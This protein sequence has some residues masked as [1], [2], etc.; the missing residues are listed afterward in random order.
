MLEHLV[1]SHMGGYYISDGDPEFIEAYC[2]TCGDYDMILTSWNT[3]ED[4]ARL[5]AL[6]RYFVGNSINNREELENKVIEYDDYCE[7]KSDIIEYIIND[8]KF[9][10]EE[11]DSIISSLHDDHDISDEEYEKIIRLSKFNSDRQVKMVKHF[12]G[13]FFTKDDKGNAKVLKKINK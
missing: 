6:L 2:E 9:N 5:N 7:D 4:S 1:R 3:L 13:S 11:T 8:I 10:E 12:A